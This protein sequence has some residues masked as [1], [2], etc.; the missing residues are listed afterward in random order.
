MADTKLVLKTQS[1]SICSAIAYLTLA[2]NNLLYSFFR[3]PIKM[4]SLTVS[5][6][7]RNSVCG[8]LSKKY[9]SKLLESKPTREPTLYNVSLNLIV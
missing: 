4:L 7:K 6:I 1:I 9:V 5:K 3:S 8:M 2:K